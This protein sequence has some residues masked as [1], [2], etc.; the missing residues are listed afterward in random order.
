[1]DINQK[2]LMLNEEDFELIIE[3]VETL[4]SKDFPAEM[5]SSLLD[6]MLSKP[7][8]DM[9]PQEIEEKRIKLAKRDA[10]KR[11]KEEEHKIF[12]KRVEILKAKLL[13]LSESKKMLT[14]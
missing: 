13:I 10:E 5:M 4:K 14:E 2:L 6:A 12:L 1:M 8:K 11:I 3:G 7:E 9:T